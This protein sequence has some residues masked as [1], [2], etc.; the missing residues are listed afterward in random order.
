MKIMRW[1]YVPAP[2]FAHSYTCTLQ[3]CKLREIDV[4]M[5]RLTARVAKTSQTGTK[6]H[7][8][9]LSIIFKDRLGRMLYTLLSVTL[10]TDAQRPACAAT[11]QKQR[12]VG[13]F[14]PL[15]H[16]IVARK[17]PC[18]A[19][20]FPARSIHPATVWCVTVRH[21]KNNLRH[22]ESFNGLRLGGRPGAGRRAGRHASPRSTIINLYTH[23]YQG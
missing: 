22:N 4:V 18:K 10:C 7:N 9:L 5:G 21:G 3:E 20:F 12:N 14:P 8:I 2:A 17:P 23:P 11:E 1:R 6:T 13:R 19:G 16:Q 15:R